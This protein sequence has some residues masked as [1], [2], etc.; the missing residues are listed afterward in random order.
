MILKKAVRRELNCSTQ[1]EG[2]TDGRTET[3]GEANCRFSQVC[4]RD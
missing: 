4:D 2:R 1:A 3:H